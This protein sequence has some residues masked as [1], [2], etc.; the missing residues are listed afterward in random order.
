MKPPDLLQFL[1]IVFRSADRL[2]L[3]V[4]IRIRSHVTQSIL[5]F[6]KTPMY[7]ILQYETFLAGQAVEHN[8]RN[9]QPRSLFAALFV[10]A[11]IRINAV[12]GPDVCQHCY[13]YR[14]RRR[15]RGVT[16]RAADHGAILSARCDG[17]RLDRSPRARSDGRQFH[18]QTLYFQQWDV[19]LNLIQSDIT[20]G[21]S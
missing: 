4:R 8:R 18:S 14:I 12:A 2:C 5:V 15:E 19:A 3:R 16:G 1:R 11:I 7:G 9:I 21:N 17:L 20:P 10:C 6:T 13:S